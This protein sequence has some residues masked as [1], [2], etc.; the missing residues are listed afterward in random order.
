MIVLRDTDSLKVFYPRLTIRATLT[1]TELYGN[2]LAPLMERIPKLADLIFVFS[3][4]LAEYNL[5]DDKIYDIID[6]VDNLSELILALYVESGLINQDD[7]KDEAHDDVQSDTTDDEQPLEVDVKQQI[8]ELL[9]QCMSIGMTEKDFYDSTFKQ[10]KRYA[11]S[12]TT[13]EKAKMQEQAF[14]DYQL[15]NMIGTSVARLF[16]ND[17]QY[18]TIEE[19]YAGIFDDTNNTNDKETTPTKE[20]KLGEVDKEAWDDGL[21]PEQRAEEIAFIRRM[22]QMEAMNKKLKERQEKEKQEQSK[23][24]E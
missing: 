24:R 9:E 11:E 12:Y 2:P 15:A 14:F 10:V 7:N 22:E 23:D 17:V 21:T 1:L 4:C 8:D 6:T 19:A 18:P 3:L 20:R 16:S 5:S 13:R